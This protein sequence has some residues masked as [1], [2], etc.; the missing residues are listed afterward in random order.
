MKH[1]SYDLIII[2]SGFAGMTCAIEATRLGLHVLVIEKMAKI[3]GN[4]II[5]DG[6]IAAPDTDLQRTRKIEDSPERMAQDM[7]EAGQY[8]NDLSLVRLIT[9][10]AKDAF[11]W[12]RSVLSVNYLDRVDYFG[13]HFVPRCYSPE[14]LTGRTM[15]KAAE[16][17]A[18]A[19]GIEVLLNTHVV[20]FIETDGVFDAV[21][22]NTSYRYG[23]RRDAT[24][25]RINASKAVVLASGGFGG[26]PD[27]LKEYAN[28]DPDTMSTN[29]KSATGELLKKVVGKGAQLIDMD[30]VQL[31]PW[32]SMDETGFGLGPLFGDY[33]ALP[34]GILVDKTTGRRFVNE[35]ADRKIVSDAMLKLPAHALAIADQ[36]AVDLA[37]WNLEKLLKKGILKSYP[38]IKDLS[39]A[40]NVDQEALHDTIITYNDAVRAKSDG[41]FNK[42]ITDQRPLDKPPYYVMRA[43]PKVHHTMGGVKIDTKGRILNTENKPI[44]KLYAIG[45]VSGGVH[46]ASRLGSCAVT[47]CVV[48]GLEVA[49]YL[50]EKERS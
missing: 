39:D 12:T 22:V 18:E 48:M 19:L 5:S 17:H 50:A 49:R 3:G 8:R 37:G 15:I 38:S 24:Y 10:R 21:K 44:E 6:G 36:S 1:D 11:E 33:V 9:T 46:G 23:K 29:K 42:P 27:L 28:I 40:H 20:D 13:G 25:E 34:Y 26:D 35:L 4:S 2:G 43:V 32:A 41:D 7:L 30:Q 14:G 31:G 45:E 16:R 47:E